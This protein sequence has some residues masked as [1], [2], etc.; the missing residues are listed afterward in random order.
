N[1][2]NLMMSARVPPSTLGSLLLAVLQ[3]RDGD[4]DR[5]GRGDSGLGGAAVV[6]PGWEEG[7]EGLLSHLQKHSGSNWHLWDIIN[8]TLIS[9]ASRS[10]TTSAA[11]DH[12][13]S[14]VSGFAPHS[15]RSPW[16]T[17]LRGGG[18]QANQL[19]HQGCFAVDWPCGHC[20]NHGEAGPGAIQNTVN[21]YDKNRHELPSSGQYLARF[22]SNTSFTGGTG[23]IQVDPGLSRV[24]SSQLFH[25]WSLKR[26]AL[27][28]PAWVT[29]GQWTRGRLELEGGIL[30]LV[31][32]FGS[33]QGQGLGAG[34]RGGDG[35]GDSS[36][37]G[38]WRP[39]DSV[40]GHRLRVVTL[41]EHPF[42]FTREV[43]EDGLCPAGQLCLD[44][45]TNR[46]D[47]IQNLFTQLH[48][49]NATV[50]D[51]EG[52]DLPEDL[53]KCCY[54][55]CIDLLE[56]LAEDM[57]FTFDL[58]IVG[59]GK[60]G[61]GGGAGRW[62]G[63]VGDLLGGTADMAV[64]SFSINSA[65]S[66]VIDFTSPFYS[67]SLGILV[68]SRDSAAP[69]GAFMWP[70]HWSM[71]VGIFVTLHLTALFLTLYEW[72]SPFGMTPHGRNRLRVFSYSSALN[73]CYAILFGRTVATK[74]PKC[75]TGRF[76]MNLW[77]LLF[78]AAV[79][80][81]EK[82]FEQVSGIHDDKLH[83]PSMGFRFGTVRESSAE[84]YMKK[85]FPEMHDYMRRFNQPTTPE[86]VHM[87]K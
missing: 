67:T 36:A 52:A 32:G 51:W 33:S 43:D 72:N 47:L 57:G 29:V 49:P 31:G 38:R 1:Q 11:V 65:R 40:A 2:F 56:K 78:A 27:G 61:A 50:T 54:G 39:G 18:P 45:R 83:H 3:G 70:L 42:V 48:N 35:Q 59:D 26:G 76:L 12:G 15:G 81:G 23:L 71:W 13:I 46:S 74:T 84:D 60:Y 17:S 53:R 22:L 66:R 62:T 8:L 68:R 7:G 79:M 30:G 86:G 24:L 75:W 41:V 63:L 73:L 58:Y 77:A 9:G 44:P 19:L 34:V 37:G 87:L 10:I 25:V 82:T 64:S 80:V 69:I 21:C 4:R 6:C 16:T 55:Y 20:G 85:S 5:G 28:Q 14:L